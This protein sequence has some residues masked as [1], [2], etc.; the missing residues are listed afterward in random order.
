MGLVRRL[1]QWQAIMRTDQLVVLS[2][3]VLEAITGGV[4]RLTA[5][6]N[7]AEVTAA[8]TALKGNFDDL[9]RAQ[10]TKSSSSSSDQMMPMMMM[11]MMRR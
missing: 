11:M 1:L 10:A 7:Q 4:A 2:S 5:R 9:A 6:G 3:H 8:V